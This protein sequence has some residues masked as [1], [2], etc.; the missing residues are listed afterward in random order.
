MIIDA[1]AHGFHGGFLDE[2]A[3]SGGNWSKKI[4]T[5]LLYASRNKPSYLN[6]DL[7]LQHLDE[8]GIGLQI[9]TPHNSLLCNLM[10]L[11][12]KH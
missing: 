10:S 12:V 11:S 5:D 1:F 8:N 2:L 6:I 9:V 3:E 7:R 4:V